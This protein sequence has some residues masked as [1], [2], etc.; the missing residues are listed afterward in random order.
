MSLSISNAWKPAAVALSTA[1]R[2]VAQ[3]IA[4]LGRGAVGLTGLLTLMAGFALTSSGELREQALA[5]FMSA[6]PFSS[7]D[8]DA[9]AERL[10]AGAEARDGRWSHWLSASTERAADPA[11]EQVTR[12]LARRYRVAENAVRQIVGEAFRSGHALGIDPLLILAVTAIE[13][14]L[15][16][17]AQS[18][19]GAQGLMQVMTRVHSERFVSHGGDHAALDPIA[20][21]RVGSEIL[22]DL[23]RAG[24]SVERGLQLYVGAGQLPDDGGYAARVL[25]EM[26]RIK[27]AA[28]SGAREALAADSRQDDVLVAR[29]EPV[30]AS[31][32]ESQPKARNDAI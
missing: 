11:Q 10:P 12:Y 22:R 16:P 32:R 2:D 19:V 9:R 7:T 3:G 8:P 13:S 27:R 29:R 30:A 25:G 23:I 6:A 15:N 20:N 28:A 14:S 31:T 1:G 18:P 24:G 4:I 26:A 21:L 5:Q 17:F